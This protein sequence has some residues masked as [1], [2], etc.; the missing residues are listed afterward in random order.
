MLQLNYY[1]WQKSSGKKSAFLFFASCLERAEKITPS[2]FLGILLHISLCFIF[3]IYG[4]LSLITDQEEREKNQE[5][6][7]PKFPCNHCW[8]NHWI[9][10][11]WDHSV[12]LSCCLSFMVWEEEKVETWIREKLPLFSKALNNN[13]IT[14]PFVSCSVFSK[15][16]H[17]SHQ[18]LCLFSHYIVVNIQ[19]KSSDTTTETRTTSCVRFSLPMSFKRMH[20]SHVKGIKGY[21]AS[22]QASHAEIKKSRETTCFSPFLFMNVLKSNS[23][24]SQ[25]HIETKWGKKRIPRMTTMIMMKVCMKRIERLPVL[26]QRPFRVTS[27]FSSSCPSSSS[28]FSLLFS[29]QG[30]NH[31][32]G[33]FCF[34]L[35]EGSWRR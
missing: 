13:K 20:L 5:D 14:H 25:V 27:F 18:I 23:L 16:C 29:L 21:A 32:R 34:F 35:L 9:E 8:R 4:W 11:T 2:H 3:W 31:E 1:Y 30:E 26:M 12:L 22:R 24:G 15:V 7:L 33:M 28:R 17:F 6:S 10:A 19:V